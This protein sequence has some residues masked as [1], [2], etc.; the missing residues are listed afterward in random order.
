MTLEVLAI[1]IASCVTPD[2]ERQSLCQAE[3][4][5]CMANQKLNT[6]LKTEGDRLSLC[7]ELK[8]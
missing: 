3:L 1:L 2:Y 7:I 5:A 8:K 4:L 6:E